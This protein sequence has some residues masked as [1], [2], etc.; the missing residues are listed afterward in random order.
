MQNTSCHVHQCYRWQRQDIQHIENFLPCSYICL[1]TICSVSLYLH[2]LV[3]L[4][5]LPSANT[6]SDMQQTMLSPNMKW[7]SSIKAKTALTE[8]WHNFQHLTVESQQKY[9]NK[10][11]VMD[12]GQ[13]LI[14][15]HCHYAYYDLW[16]NLRFP[17]K[18]GIDKF[19]WDLAS[20]VGREI[21]RAFLIHT[22][23]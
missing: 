2:G 18:R 20:P 4:S 7:H 14:R 3:R 5:S 21:P 23:L 8:I 11:T 9:K 19:T 16:N 10:T 15:I 12:Q 6:K 17:S 13:P 1:I 22:L